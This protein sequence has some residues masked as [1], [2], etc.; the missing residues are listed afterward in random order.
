[1]KLNTLAL[2]MG[3]LGAAAIAAAAGESAT[4]DTNSGLLSLAQRWSSPRVC[5][6]TA[7]LPAALREALDRYSKPFEN[8]AAKRAELITRLA[9][10]NHCYYAVTA[11]DYERLLRLYDLLP[12]SMFAAPADERFFTDTFVFV[13][14]GSVSAASG[15]AQP[16]NL[17]FSFPIDGTTWG[18]SGGFGSGPNVLLNK[19][20]GFFGAPNV[21]RAREL[22]RQAFANWR[23][24]GG[25]TYTE[26]ADD[27]TNETT[28]T[29]RVASRG[30]VRI[31]SYSLDGVFNVLAYN[32]F[33]SNGSDMNLDA[34]D[35][36]GGSFYSSGGAYVFFRN[37]VAHEH[38]HGMAYIH[39]VPCDSTKLMEP[40]AGTGF[41]TIQVDDRRGIQRNYGDRNAGNNAAGT[42]KDL[43][44]MTSPS[45]RS[46]IVREASTNGTAGFNNTDED[47]Y[48]FTLGSAQ[49]VIITVDPT[50]GS[51]SNGQQSSGC[52]GSLSTINADQ[53][54]NLNIELRDSAG[55]TVLQTAASSAAGVNEVLNAGSL[56][57]G[58]YTVR[59]FDV[60]PNANQTLQTYDMTLSVAGATA[61]PQAIAGVNKRIGQ[62]FPCWF[63]GDL[64]S[65]ALQPGAFISTYQWDF[66]NNG[67][68]DASGAE[69]STSYPSVGL[70]TV[71]LRVTDSNGR[72]DTDFI[73]VDV[74]SAVPP[75]APG[76]FN[77]LS[78]ANGSNTTDTTPTLDWSDASSVDSYSLTLDDN[79]DFSSPIINGL[80]VFGSSIT[81]SPG[82]VSV[83]NTYFWR[84]N[85]INAFGTTAS[86]PVT[87]SFSV[88][89]TPPPCPGD[90]NGD[91]QRNT[92]DL[93]VLLGSFGSNVTPGT[94]GDLN[95]DGT[96]N[97]VDL[98]TLLGVFGIPCP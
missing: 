34:D 1:M 3:I 35:F 50:G 31:G 37:V 56:A 2:G 25:I 66:D 47:W 12:A 73:T 20:N 90:I 18:T 84:V 33:T 36:V 94:S 86:T 70:R 8:P 11:E 87:A 91:G 24:N 80:A 7:K 6:D 68:F 44:N 39:S 16:V 75:P 67:T 89:T 76:P 28:G 42:A 97:T 46:A 29:G 78:P 5:E 59:V 45:V 61:N 41:D 26:V 95:G 17:T 52:T 85:A 96:V 92:N 40:Q 77:L 23:R 63:R 4:V 55:T 64:N 48:R 30:D 27:N 38:G 81:L 21:D 93:T 14:N 32:N 49:P 79:A 62:G 19:L 83:G 74:F 54:G 43:G 57:A 98:T 10:G 69:V 58:T 88:I 60:G 72:T 82:T 9:R 15:R 71:A 13:G 22:I 53:A 51:Y 65:R